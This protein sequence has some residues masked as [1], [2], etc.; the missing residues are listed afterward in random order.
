MFIL[1]KC[2]IYYDVTL[3]HKKQQKFSEFGN[4]NEFCFYFHV[5]YESPSQDTDAAG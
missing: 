4:P 1:D 2:Q 5:Y 3:C